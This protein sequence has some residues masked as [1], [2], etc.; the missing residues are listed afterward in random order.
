[1]FAKDVLCTL[2]SKVPVI[3][4]LITG[5]LSMRAFSVIGVVVILVGN[6]CAQL[7]KRV[8]LTHV[9]VVDVVTGSEQRNTSVVIEGSRIKS[10]GAG[11]PARAGARIIDANGKYLIPGLW[12]MHVHTTFGDWFPGAR[13][14]ALPLFIANGVTGVRDMGGDLQTLQKWR[15]HIRNGRLIGPRMFI[16]GPMLDGAP[17][18]YPASVPIKNA[19]EAREWV[20]KLKARGSNFIK[21]QS[22]I[23]RDAYFAVADEAKKRG[24]AFVGHVP[25]AVR[26]S[27]ASDAGQ[28][29]IEHLTGIFEGCSDNEDRLI[30]GLPKTR[31]ILLQT[32]NSARAKALISKLSTNGTWQVPTLVTERV[33][34]TPEDQNKRVQSFARYVPRYWQRHTWQMVLDEINKGNANDDLKVRRTFFKAELDIV[35]KMHHAGVPLLSG[36]DTAPGPWVLPG[37]SI[38]DELSLLVKAGLTPIEA[39]RTATLNPA[40]FLGIADQF[41]TIDIGKVADMVL[42]DADPIANIES[43]RKIAAVFAN[44]RL[45][46][47]V[48]LDKILAGVEKSARNSDFS[49]ERSP[50]NNRQP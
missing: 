36:T 43:T 42:L 48:K 10:V 45:L 25:N 7:Q 3:L 14:I 19:K 17:L 34:W 44:G 31:H 23:P 47:R 20:D 4:W 21:I 9:T 33:Q 35:N 38:H 24:I 12:D 5:S 49:L 18:P 29:S 6:L 13:D 39:L 2:I 40:K 28:K 16:A 22:L 41:G 32:Y 37:F 8:I 50:K 26:A 30:R 27:E 11:L 1:M 46:D 15:E